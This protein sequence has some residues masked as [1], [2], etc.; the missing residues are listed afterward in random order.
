MGPLNCLPKR[1]GVVRS[2]LNVCGTER[3][4]KILRKAPGKMAHEMIGATV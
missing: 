4:A 1:R 3:G 2:A